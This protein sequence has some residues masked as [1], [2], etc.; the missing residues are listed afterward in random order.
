[1]TETDVLL[2]IP[3][4]TGVAFEMKKGEV[5]RVVDI[6]GEQVSD[7]IA[8]DPAGIET[9][10]SGRT[11]DYNG[12]IRL[13]QGHILYSNQS[14]PM[15]TIVEDTVG[16]HDFLFAP[17]SP[18]MFVK[19]YGFE[20]DHPSCFRNLADNLRQFGIEGSRIGTTFNI[21][22]HASLEP[23]G[24]IKV[25]PPVSKPGDAVRL[26]AEMDLVVGL[27]ACSAEQSN[28]WSF[29][30]IGYQISGTNKDA[31]GPALL[32]NPANRLR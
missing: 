4:Q 30:P 22:M 29:K 3:P 8:F 1:M 25:L 26:R 15:F 28:N 23:T 10:S 21:F 11:I 32:G 31:G 17:C 18:E 19:L 9:L 20:P 27:T 14:R 5:L 13:T 16:V 7:L 24:E 2:E 6:M 12:T